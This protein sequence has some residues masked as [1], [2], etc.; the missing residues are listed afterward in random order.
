MEAKSRGSGRNKVVHIRNLGFSP[1]FLVQEQKITLSGVAFLAKELTRSDGVDRSKV[2]H[3]RNLGFPL[4]FL[5]QEQK[6]T[7]SR[8][9]FLLRGW[10]PSREDRGAIKLFTLVIF[11]FARQHAFQRLRENLLIE[12]GASLKKGPIFDIGDNHGVW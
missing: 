8:V 12:R 5:V 9:I 1:A 7:L 6:V 2:V 10:K 4:A 3:I 11:E